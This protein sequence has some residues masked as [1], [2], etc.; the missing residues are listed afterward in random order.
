[1]RNLKTRD[2]PA[3]CRAVKKIGL[4]E[5]FRKIAMEADT[6]KDIPV[7][8]ID[9]VWELFDA[10]T[11]QDGENALYDFLSGPFEMTAEEVADLDLDKLFDGLRQLVADSN[12]LGFFKSAAKLMM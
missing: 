7:L 5:Q 8:G 3:F 1:M 4:K 9:F 2:L 10:A 6:V 11:E 12:L